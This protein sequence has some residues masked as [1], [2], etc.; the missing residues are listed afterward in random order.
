MPQLQGQCIS[1][2]D[3]LLHSQSVL[4]TGDFDWMYILSLYSFKSYWTTLYLSPSLFPS[5]LQSLLVWAQISSTT[6]SI[7]KVNL[8]I[9]LQ[10]CWW[11]YWNLSLRFAWSSLVWRPPQT[12][13]DQ[14]NTYKERDILAENDQQRTASFP[15]IPL[16]A[17]KYLL[18]I[19]YHR[20]YIPWGKVVFFSHPSQLL[21]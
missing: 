17:W 10:F 15:K 2:K 5:P 6:N 21:N 4:E 11:S 16:L 9:Y 3:N 18:C 8:F 20:K 14:C 12:F 1:F 19:L 13:G 7:H